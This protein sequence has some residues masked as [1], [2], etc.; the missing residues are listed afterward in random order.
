MVCSSIGDPHINT[1]SG[2]HCDAMGLGVFPLVELPNVRVHAFHC[3]VNTGGN[4][5]GAS[6]VAAV[7]MHA[8]NSRIV[9]QG[10]HVR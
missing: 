8:G 10:S 6:T 2:F 4:H 1:F 9:I 5:D 3:P 7:A